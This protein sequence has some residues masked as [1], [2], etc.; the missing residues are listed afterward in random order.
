LAVTV[1]EFSAMFSIGEQAAA[2]R[3]QRL[4]EEGKAYRTVKNVARGNG[5]YRV[6]AYRLTPKGKKR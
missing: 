1:R 2:R 3:L 4:V 5:W 6:P